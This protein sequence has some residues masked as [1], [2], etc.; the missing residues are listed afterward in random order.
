MSKT[1]PIQVKYSKSEIYRTDLS[2]FLI[3]AIKL[4]YSTIG[5]EIFEDSML[6]TNENVYYRKHINKLLEKR[7]ESPRIEEI[8]YKSWLMTDN[9]V[10]NSFIQ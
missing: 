9:T 2:L 8:V 7:H 1:F 10:K 3:Y 5:Y 4:V 6:G